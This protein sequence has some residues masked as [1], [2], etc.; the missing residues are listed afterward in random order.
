[1]ILCVT[2][3]TYQSAWQKLTD[4]EYAALRQKVPL[5]PA[6]KED[7]A[8]QKFMI[9]DD[10]LRA[11]ATLNLEVTLSDDHN[12]NTM[13]VKLQERIRSLELS[14]EQSY[15]FDDRVQIAIP[16]QALMKI[17][18]VTYEED[19]CTDKIQDLLNEGWRIIA[20]CP[21][22]AQRRPDYILGRRKSCQM[23]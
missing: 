4:E 12:V 7:A 18:E 23:I 20:V 14:K 11:L 13:L 22:N 8:Y 1:M 15:Q 3:S 10:G 2:I 6:K 16:D 21:P 17:D 5:L 19:C 9:D